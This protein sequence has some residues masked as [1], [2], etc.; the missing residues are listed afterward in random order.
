[1][2]NSIKSIILKNIFV[3]LMSP[4]LINFSLKLLSGN[5][6]II[7]YFLMIDQIL[8]VYILNIFFYYYLS[9]TINKSTKLNSLSLSLVFFFFSFFVFDLFLLLINK[10]IPKKVTILVVV[11]FWAVFFIFKL[12]NK[13]DILKL[14]A[15]YFC[16]FYAN[17]KYFYELANLDGYIELNSDVPLQW[18][19]LADLISSN[20]Y[21]FAFTN[22]VIDGQGLLLSYLQSLIFNLNFY[23]YDFQFVRLNANIVLFFTLLLIIDLNILRKNKIISSITLGALLLN[24]DWLTYLFL[25]SLMLEGIVSFV[26]TSFV[27]NLDKFKTKDLNIKSLLF[28]SFFSCMIFT[29]QFISTISLLLLLYIFI[30]YKNRNIIVVVFF[31]LL[32]FSYKKVFTP[33]V[34]G[35]ELLN[36]TSISQLFKD[37]IFFNNLEISNISKIILQLLIDRPVSFLIFLFFALNV[38][39]FLSSE[40][41]DPNLNLYFFIVTL[42][43]ILI[44]ILYTVWWKDFGIQSS[45]RY[46]MNIFYLLFIGIVK[47]LDSIGKKI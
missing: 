29:K 9:K 30:R 18:F 25:D 24:S 44:F 47:H 22:N 19:K 6:E 26:F 4:I 13:I 40:K 12:K 2:L 15:I 16:S 45:F 32:D 38:Y 23:F 42:N 20:N 14:I 27:I 35:F 3:I 8:I 31:Y 39:R 1:M 43:F 36:G 46:I 28:F 5:V 41:F 7:N 10:S 33:N 21:F 11:F 17:N 34:E 37:I